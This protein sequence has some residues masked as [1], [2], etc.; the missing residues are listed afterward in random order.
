MKEE[1]IFGEQ[2]KGI[3]YRY[4][5]GSYGIV[6]NS[7]YQ[8]C[9]VRTATGYALPGGGIEEGETLEQALLREVN[10]ETGFIVSVQQALG[11]AIHF[12]HSETE[13]YIKKGCF[14]YSCLF[15]AI[16]KA[17]SEKD[18][19]PEW[20]TYTEALDRLK[21]KEQ[22]HHWAVRTFFSSETHHP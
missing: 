3:D 10:E 5:P 6:V 16:E 18:H 4:R 13:G 9:I 20:C 17:P 7:Q 14:Y 15:R 1:L 21:E 19:T 2:I 12:T 8:I 22:A 11:T